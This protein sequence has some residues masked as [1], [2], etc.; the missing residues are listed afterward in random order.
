MQQMKDLLKKALIV[1]FKGR[2]M[3]SDMRRF[4]E[5][6][7]KGEEIVAKMRKEKH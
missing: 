5:R 7:K 4:L 3:T 2:T 1:D 6:K